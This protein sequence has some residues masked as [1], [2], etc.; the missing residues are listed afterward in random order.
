M[1]R[2][3]EKAALVAQAQALP[4]LQ[5]GSS[6]SNSSSA[7]SSPS[8]SS[9]TSG[10]GL[11]SGLVTAAPECSTVLFFKTSGP[12]WAAFL[13]ASAASF[14]VLPLVCLWC[15]QLFTRLTK[16]PVA[17]ADAADTVL[18]QHVVGDA[19]G[20]SSGASEP[21][22]VVSW[23][24]CPLQRLNGVAWFEFRKSRHFYD[25]KHQ[26]FVQLRNEL[27]E[28]LSD[29]QRRVAAGGHTAARADELLE[30]FGRNELD[31]A[32][33]PWPR[34]LLR[35]VLHPFYLFQVASALIWLSEAYT[36]YALIIMAMSAIS[37]AWEVYSQCA[38]DRKLHD[39]VRVDLSVK[40]V[41]G[42]R[43]Q[44][45]SAA[46][47]VV[48]D[49]V[50]V[51]D[52]L[53]P[54]DLLLLAGD[55]TADESTLTGEAIPITKQAVLAAQAAELRLEPA[56]LKTRHKQCVLHAGST[57]LATK[58]D[59]STRAV[60]LATGFATSK[61]EL[62]RAIVFPRP[63]PFRLE[64]DSYRFLAALSVVALLAFIKRLVQASKSDIVSTGDAIV[65]S[66][67]LV[68]IAVPPAL[69]LV[70]TVGVGFAL[71]RL[72][73]AAIFCINSQRINLAGHVDCF[74]FDK[75]GTL[76]SDHL[77][78]QG[79]DEC[80]SPS[81][82]SSGGGGSAPAF[83]GLQQEVD[84][85]SVH[86]I[87]GLAT[88]HG[89]TERCGRVT[90]YAL[91]LDMFRATGY[92]LETNV[93][94]QH[95]PTAPFHVLISSPIGKTFG[96]V[97]RYLFDAAL[98]RSSVLIEDFESGQRVVYTKG[99]PEALH[100]I[101]NPA[102][103][104]ADFHAKA[105]AYSYQGY[106]VVALASK[107]YPVTSDV[108]AREAMECRLTFLGFVLFLNKIKPESPYV[109]TTLED[110]GVDV[111]IITGDNAFTAIHVARKLNM[112]LES[113]V[114]LLD[115]ESAADPVVAFA[116]V[117][118]LATSP[119]A[120]SSASASATVANATARGKSVWTPVD[121]RTFLTL[122]DNNTVALTGAALEGLQ[123]SAA[124]A[125]LAELVAQTKIFA[126]IRPQQKTWLVETLIARGKCVGMVGDGT[127]DC[128]ALKA[129]HVGLALSDA[130]ASIVAP[131]T[132]RGRRVTDVVA[133]LVEGRAALS[134]SF[135]AFKF[136]VLYSIIQL[137]MSSLMNDYASQ[138]SNN[139]FLFDDLVVVF[140]LSVLM[141]RTAAAERLGRD[142]PPAT[143]FA[144]TIVA[145]LAGQILLFLVTLG[146][147]LS[148]A[149]A[150][151]WYCAAAH[152]YELTRARGNATTPIPAPCY[153]F[154]PGEP[155]DLTQHSYENSVLWLFGH[156]QYWVVALA[157]NLRDAFRRPLVS[158]RL[159]A[160]YLAVLLI[161]LLV[162]L[163]SYESEQATRTVGVDTTL[164]V[165][166]L[167]KSFCTSLFFLFL[168]DVGL[169][170]VWELGVVGVFVLRVQQQLALQQASAS[171][172]S[173]ASAAGAGA[174]WRAV[175][176]AAGLSRRS[177]TGS[178]PGSDSLLGNSK[179]K[180]VADG[181]RAKAVMPADAAVATRSDHAVEVAD[182]DDDGEEEDV[183]HRR[184][185]EMV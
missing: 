68:T 56:T 73:A 80:A 50:V 146:I 108:P 102:T 32:P 62:F 5:P 15:P 149:R 161:V 57:V 127:N 154:E 121:P 147:A 111:R 131:F 129:A 132:S 138:M 20:S 153:A 110:A 61:G 59:G 104:P 183:L 66:L 44:T 112:E 84:V 72:E 81:S 74:C 86:A 174:W 69:P 64:S 171:S 41:R 169:A 9:G 55:C 71:T 99:S 87:V 156:L 177:S 126:R 130:D 160:G 70:L 83:L 42:G 114:L 89:L 109:I 178:G 52:G 118:D 103:L 11:L 63:L 117:D 125:F 39:L 28:R 38:N 151:D 170:L 53:V 134:T 181:S 10:T 115:V 122:A 113:S 85:L 29:T 75:T 143:L 159:F 65:S 13:A 21:R 116:D 43:T 3:G 2:D 35:K 93:H 105:R 92:S 101:C 141:V 173:F 14:G 36:T 25:A 1:R 137:T 97:Q 24:E 95:T 180:G 91:E 166:K 33:Q 46:Q 158:N 106:Y 30:V 48:G 155:A 168:F 8:S 27:A 144:P 82:P 17:S 136:M 79:V 139:Q 19:E 100:A 45:V 148:A 185:A 96:V 98:Q 140:G 164:G 58:A 49:L 128:G 179:R 142:V 76:S 90:G 6:H 172:S 152:A 22:R 4:P 162:Q 60:V 124:P 26:A 23:H 47:L 77:D 133:L 40:V 18:V 34:V 12:L 175:T 31:L 78:F 163:F 145:S 184:P 123:R 165:L 88:C 135:V 51:E 37:V 167:P 150:Q 7:S 54:A 67:D 94:K 176:S 120:S 107:T 157:F 16:T 182:D 119:S